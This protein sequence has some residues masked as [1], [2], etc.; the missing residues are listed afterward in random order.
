MRFLR[1]PPPG[2]SLGV[3]EV[4]EI[5]SV[6]RGLQARGRQSAQVGACRLAMDEPPVKTPPPSFVRRFVI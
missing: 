4:M 3:I 5:P 6:R 2:L 1:L